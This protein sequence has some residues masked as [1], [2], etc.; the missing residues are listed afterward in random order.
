[1]TDVAR[2]LFIQLTAGSLLLA[3]LVGA[4]AAD[5]DEPAER[6]ITRS[7]PVLL[8]PLANAPPSENAGLFVGINDFTRDPE[9]RPLRFAVHDAIEL[10]YLFVVELKLIPARNCVLA[11]SGKPSNKVVEQH[12]ATLKQ[13]GV[14]EVGATKSDVLAECFTLS[15]TARKKSDLLV[16][17]FSSHGFDDK[18]IAYVMPSDGFR[19]L[20]DESGI[21][22]NSVE[23]QMKKSAA[24][25]RLL[26]VDACQERLGADARAVGDR[27]RAMSPDFVEM[28]RNPTGQAKLA[29]C[30]VNEFSYEHSQLGGVGHGLFSYAVLEAL[31]GGATPDADKL[32]KLQGVLAYVKDY[33]REWIDNQNRLRSANEPDKAQSPSFFGEIEA[34]QMPFARRADDL[35]TLLDAVKKR[36]ATSK[37]TTALRDQHVQALERLDVADAA[38]RDFA[39]ATRDFLSGNLPESV[40]VAFLERV[41]G[42]PNV[43]PPGPLQ[44][45]FTADEAEAAQVAW[46]RH[47]GVPMDVRNSLGVELRMIPPGKF[48]M[49]S[50]EDFAQ[51]N[52]RPHAVRITPPFYAARH[53]IT[54]GQF[55]KF[56]KDTNYQTT[57][58]RLGGSGRGWDDRQGRFGFGENYTWRNPGWEQ[59]DSHPVV[60]VSWNDAQAFLTWLSD[61]EGKKYRL[62]TEAEWEYC[63][64][65]GTKSL[66]AVGD[67]PNRLV[68][69]GN[70]LDVTAM[71]FFSGDEGF[72][73]SSRNDKVSG[74]DNVA[75]TA[76]VGHFQP[77]GFGLFDFHGNVCE[78]CQ[79]RYADDYGGQVE[80]DPKG[81]ATGSERTARGGRFDTGKR[82]AKSFARNHGSPNM[83]DMILGFRVAL[84]IAR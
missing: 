71:R 55:A 72:L 47:L 36:P 51:P 68:E 65:A 80:K 60:N 79:D 27:G 78:W 20:L 61:K 41:V 26:L 34:F 84:E 43:A 63:C 13:M 29:S 1:M 2:H 45:P 3:P 83:S 12:L 31:R 58:E 4:L 15:R 16:A 9:I 42:K 48:T 10:A 6:N 52:E 18:R 39:A 70:V 14:R 54:V 38:D 8:Q 77:N 73:E 56:V 57:R 53:E 22:L 40:F 76:P 59:E 5:P 35:A 50:S 32:V 75:F 69:V 46:S 37:Y 81:A 66:Y 33:V 67:D 44:S 30:S 28:L 23:E 64:R 24:G 62:L 11:I 17:S 21:K 49:G 19:A 82:L 7:E 25:H 74:N